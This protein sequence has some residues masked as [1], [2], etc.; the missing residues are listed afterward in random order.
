[1]LPGQGLLGRASPLWDPRSGGL[2][3]ASREAPSPPASQICLDEIQLSGLVFLC[4]GC[5]AEG[6]CGL[7]WQAMGNIPVEAIHRESPPVQGLD[8]AP[9]SPPLPRHFPAP[10]CCWDTNSSMCRA[11]GLSQSRMWPLGLGDVMGGGSPWWQCRH[12][13]AVLEL[14]VLL[15]EDACASRERSL[16]QEFL[17]SFQDMQL[18]LLPLWPFLDK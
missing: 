9:C 16:C 6:G 13:V 11:S 7:C 1:M 10:C 5:T 15:R 3:A 12:E 14:A 17:G 4:G 8:A 2:L 18:P